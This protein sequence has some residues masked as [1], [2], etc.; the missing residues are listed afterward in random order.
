[1]F[2][3]DTELLD[4]PPGATRAELR[5]AAKGHIIARAELVGIA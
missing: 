1:L 3:L 5:E 2:A 4:L